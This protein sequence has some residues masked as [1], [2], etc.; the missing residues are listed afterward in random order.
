MNENQTTPAIEAISVTKRFGPIVA[1][2]N[3]SF[4]V[5]KGQIHALL[6]ENGAGKSTLVN[7]LFGLYHADQGEIYIAGEKVEMNSPHDAIDRHIGMVHQHFQLVPVLSVTEN[8]VLGHEPTKKRGI[9]DL[10]KAYA[11]VEAL[12]KRYGLEVDPRA[13]VED[14]PIGTQQRVEILRS[15]YRKADVLILDEPTAVLTP[16]ETDHLLE[17]LRGLAAEGVAIIFIT[18]KLR[19]VMA[20]A[21]HVTVM[22]R[23]KVV[24]AIDPSE[25]DQA[26]LAEMMVGRS[27]VLRIAKGEAKA[28]APVLTI[29]SLSAL[30]DRAQTAVDGL[31]LTVHAG[32]IFGIAG[33]E[34][35]GQRELVEAITGLRK[36]ISGSIMLEDT[37]LA[38]SSPREISEQGVAHVPEDR[39]KHGLVGPHSVADNLVLNRYFKAP[40]ARRG[41]RQTGA[42][43]AEAQ[44]LV[45]QYDVRTASINSPV[46]TLSGGNKQKVIA[47]RELSQNAKLLVAAQPTRGIDVGSIEF[48][49][50]QLVD[51]RDDGIAVLLVSA[52]LDEIMSLSDRIGVIYQGRLVAIGKAEDFTRNQIGQLM[53][54]GSTDA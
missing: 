28:G 41:I 38:G 3:V 34:G 33:V 14:L 37:E 1:N 7:I 22:R 24:G 47:A 30:D 52:E 46:R 53:A 12:G 18:H 50:Q 17:V 45:D 26:G 42:I 8:I 5:E 20:V 6:G 29:D 40:F 35:N 51:Q 32:E 48:V 54:S 19:E 23:G 27:V 13:I 10:E 15:L 36:T 25:T 44:K 2:E 4:R 31:C 43:N 16:Q 9:L 21:D 39:E 11:E 49:H